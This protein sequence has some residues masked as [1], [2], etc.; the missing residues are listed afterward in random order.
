VHKLA[1]ITIR[2]EPCF[3]VILADVWL[4]I[5]PTK[6]TTTAA[7]PGYEQQQQHAKVSTSSTCKLPTKIVCKQFPAS[8]A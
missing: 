1:A 7:A 4:V 3:L 5:K 8:R 2:A 6:T